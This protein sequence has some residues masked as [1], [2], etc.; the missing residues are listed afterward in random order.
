VAREQYGSQSCDGQVDSKMFKTMILSGIQFH[1]ELR[2]CHKN[3]NL[4]CNISLQEPFE[5]RLIN[6]R[7]NLVANTENEYC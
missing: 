4:A 6:E 2:N 1:V 5:R 3:R 7:M